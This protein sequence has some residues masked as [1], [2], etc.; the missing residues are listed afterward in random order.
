MNTLNC[1]H[2]TV[3]IGVDRFQSLI[4]FPCLPFPVVRNSSAVIKNVDTCH[5]SLASHT[6]LVPLS[7]VWF[8][9]LLRCWVSASA[10]SST[11]SCIVLSLCMQ[12]LVVSQLDGNLT[13]P[14]AGTFVPLHLSILFLIPTSITRQPANPLWF[15]L[16]KNFVEFL[17]DQNPVFKEYFNVSWRK[18]SSAEEEKQASIGAGLSCSKVKDRVLIP[19]VCRNQ[20]MYI[21]IMTPD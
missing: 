21:D 11:L 6:D 14:Y 17:I 9:G 3:C 12:A 8:L 5:H 20:Y 13:A 7:T 18:D 1:Q 19:N 10:A 16:H 15:G 2:P 4:L